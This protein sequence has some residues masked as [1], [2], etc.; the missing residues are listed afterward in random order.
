MRTPQQL[1]ELA[2][3]YV[4]AAEQKNNEFQ[5]LSKAQKERV[6]QLKETI[7]AKRQEEADAIS[8][9]TIDVNN[10]KLSKPEAGALKAQINGNYTTIVGCLEAELTELYPSWRVG[11]K[12]NQGIVESGDKVGD[13]AGKFLRAPLQGLKKVKDNIKRHAGDTINVEKKH[14]L[15]S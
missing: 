14:G 3:R 11:D 2:G 1:S 6:K 5:K 13:V 15:L 12:I 4:N 9:V 10:G 8:A 7:K